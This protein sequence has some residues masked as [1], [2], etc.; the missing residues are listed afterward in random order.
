[1]CMEWRG[2]ASLPPGPGPG[3]GVSQGSV[4]ATLWLQS[5]GPILLSGLLPDVVV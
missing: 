2:G 3:V 5:P 1:M 4:L